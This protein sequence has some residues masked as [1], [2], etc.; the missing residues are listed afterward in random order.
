MPSPGLAARV[1]RFHINPILEKHRMQGG[2][3][4]QKGGGRLL[5]IRGGSRKTVAASS[6]SS[7]LEYMD[8]KRMQADTGSLRN[9]AEDQR[10]AGQQPG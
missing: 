3:F 9:G 6:L 5:S 7:T 10:G 8:E 4:E 2:V 1:H